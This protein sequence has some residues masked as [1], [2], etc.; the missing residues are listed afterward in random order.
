MTD[1]YSLIYFRKI[2]HKVYLNG[3]RKSSR[4][5][6]EVIVMKGNTAITLV[7]AIA[8]AFILVMFFELGTNNSWYKDAKN[9]WIPII[10]QN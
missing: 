3:L 1:K 2:F 10:Y 6:Y 4:K 5:Y 9:R 7:I 8:I